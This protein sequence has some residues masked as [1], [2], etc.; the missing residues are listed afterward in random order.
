M[1]LPKD[2]FLCDSASFEP[3][4]AKIRQGVWPAEVFE[5]KSI[6]K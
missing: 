4:Q 3:S 1:S 2:T 6:Y 5:N